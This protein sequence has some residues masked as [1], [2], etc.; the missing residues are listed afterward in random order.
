MDIFEED[1]AR[2]IKLKS[3]TVLER[4]LVYDD[5]QRKKKDDQHRLPALNP[6]KFFSM[7]ILSIVRETKDSFLYKFK[8][9]E[10]RCLGLSTG[11]HIVARVFAENGV[12][13]TRQYTPISTLEQKDWFEVLIKLYPDGVMSRE[14]MKWSVGTQ[15]DW[16]GPYGGFK[17]EMNKYDRL[18]L[19]ACGTGIA[20]MVNIIR[21][22]LD[23]EEDETR[24]LLLYACRSQHDIFLKETIDEFKTYWN[25]SVVYFL[26]QVCGGGVNDIWRGVF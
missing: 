16:K 7:E 26:S 18:V 20:P 19:L 13:I 2:W 4:K 21:E 6:G 15:V 11:Q 17:Y 5:L 23:K 8:L 24:I 25:F 1:M 22:I 9:P 12:P 10:G 3:L 14:I